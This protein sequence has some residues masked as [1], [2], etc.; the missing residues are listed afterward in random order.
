M[1]SIFTIQKSFKSKHSI[2][3][4]VCIQIRTECYVCTT[5][6]TRYISG[7]SGHRCCYNAIFVADERTSVGRWQI[8][9]TPKQAISQSVRQTGFS[10]KLSVKKTD[11]FLLKEATLCAKV[12]RITNR[13]EQNSEAFIGSSGI[14]IRASMPCGGGNSTI[15]KRNEIQ[16]ND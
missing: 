4:P 16:G 2:I 15:S 1:V 11:G 5:S 14:R 8:D 10:H 6:H 9:D 12:R 13:A 3:L 7:C